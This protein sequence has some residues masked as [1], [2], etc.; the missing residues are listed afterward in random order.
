M[1][2]M[3]HEDFIERHWPVLERDP[4]RHNLLLGLIEAER[5][6]QDP[7]L[8]T[9]DLGGPGCCAIYSPGRNIIL[10]DLDEPTCHRLA[11]EVLPLRPE[12]VLGPDRTA[13]WYV[14]RATAL[15]QRFRV[16][17][18]QTIHALNGP[19]R[20][21][22][23]PGLPRLAAPEDSELLADWILA[24]HDEAV[25]DDPRP[26]RE[27]LLKASAYGRHFLWTVDGEPVAFARIARRMRRCGAIGPVYTA[28]EHRSRGYAAAITAHLAERLQSEGMDCVALYTDQRNPASNRC[29][30]KIGFEPH[31]ESWHYLRTD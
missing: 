25:P 21:P 1:A 23:V 15:G 30:A 7:R 20:H 10:A 22:A 8:F 4:A 6:D 11:E 17:V 16:P 19:P 27:S 13:R 3:A 12:G 5:T 18:P 31:C 9:L 26:E 24:F 2:A 29:Y 14:E 28:P